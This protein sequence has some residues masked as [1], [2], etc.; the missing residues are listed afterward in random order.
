MGGALDATNVVKNVKMNVVTTIAMDHQKFLGDTIEEIAVQ[1]AG[2][3]TN[4]APVV[5][6]QE[7]SEALQVI[8]NRCE[9]KKAPSLCSESK[10]DQR[11]FL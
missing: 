6:V 4:A 1:K 8:P 2:I 9:E 10:R 7:S 5:T 3:I 11:S